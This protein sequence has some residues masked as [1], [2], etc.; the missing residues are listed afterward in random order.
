MLCY[1]NASNYTQTCPRVRARC[2]TRCFNYSPIKKRKTEIGRIRYLFLLQRLL[3]FPSHFPTMH[4]NLSAAAI[5][6]AAMER[7]FFF[8][9]R[10]LLVDVNTLHT[11]GSI[12]RQCQTVLTELL[13]ASSHFVPVTRWKES[14]G[15]GASSCCRRCNCN[16]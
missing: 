6:R 8:L 1:A 7:L 4:R 10:R 12:Q 5:I 3:I 15:V 9:K 14:F 16:L 11:E 2:Q 13:F